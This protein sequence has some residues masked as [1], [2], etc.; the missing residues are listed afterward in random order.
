MSWQ[1]DPVVEAPKGGWQDD[2]VVDPP[3]KMESFARG[4]ANNV[5]LLPQVI[6]AGK[7]N[8][9]AMIPG[10]LV[11]G[12]VV[13][14][15]ETTPY[16]ENLKN[17][18]QK[19]EE[20]K[21]ANPKTYG[22]GAVTGALAPLAIPGVGEALEGAPI[23]GN[24]ALGAANAISNVDLTQDKGTTAKEA[25]LGAGVGG[26]LGAIPKAAGV[27]AKAIPEAVK[28]SV[29]NTTTGVLNLA[30]QLPTK[31]AKAMGITNPEEA[32]SVINQKLRKYFPNVADWNS[33][34][35][36]KLGMIQQA[37][38]QASKA[39]GQV[40]DATTAKEG[41]AIPEVN[42]AIDKI[43]SES[44]KYN[45]LTSSSNQESKKELEDTAY[46]LMKLQDRG[47]IGRAHV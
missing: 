7:E 25:A 33:S 21:A 32:M 15:S 3:G 31:I 12:S 19:A 1:D 40:I 41:G 30:G 39:I 16:S 17:W 42:Q 20:A 44:S 4:A 9:E 8:P 14:P 24:A 35:S 47:Q 45:D 38:E 13:R 18:N 23:L 10:A 36:T 43:G 5:P 6:A 26:A 28:R 2:P 37:H 34:A 29:S 11:N 27:V 22:A 46:K